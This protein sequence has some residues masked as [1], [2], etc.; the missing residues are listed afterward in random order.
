MICPVCSKLVPDG[1]L[2]CP[3]CH[4]ELGLTQRLSLSDAVW[5]PSCG[6][7]VPKGT[8][9]CPSCGHVLIEEET[10]VRKTRDLDLPDIGNTGSFE[11]L[12]EAERTAAMTRIESA[13]PPPS[14]EDSAEAIHDRIP[15]MRSFVV[16]AILAVVVIG[17][18]ALLIT[19]PWDPYAN[20]TSA[21]T[22]A[23]T[24]M[25]GF[26]GTVDNLSGQDGT[27]DS[28]SD[29]QSQ[30]ATA[31]VESDDPF[32][33]LKTCYTEL[34]DLSDK[35]DANQETLLSDGVSNLD[36]ATREDGQSE[37][38]S[39]SVEVSNLITRMLAVQASTEVY[40]DQASRLVTM[41]NWLRNRCDALTAG[42]ELSVSVDDPS[43]VSAAIATKVSGS[44]DYARLF[45]EA[46]SSAEPVE[47]TE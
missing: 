45:S 25:Q 24:S 9:T 13:I 16:A 42:W 19:H 26:P 33:R 4:A 27:S 2:S 43:E 23:D 38:A 8:E 11:S 18:A 28:A 40:A 41:G 6:A 34:G 32:E 17:G 47:A 3:H 44:N 31:D 37:L 10:P 30:D 29:E 22:P 46:Y 39:L 14:D 20:R 12:S 1:A 5:C 36:L 15:H 21:T 7:L 35:V